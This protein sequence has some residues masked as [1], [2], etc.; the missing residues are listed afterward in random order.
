M[1][2]RRDFKRIWKQAELDTSFKNMK[3]LARLLK[4]RNADTRLRTL[5]KIRE[6]MILI[7]PKGYFLLA[8]RLID[9][10]DN[11]CRWQAVIIIGRFVETNPSEVWKV[12]TK[13]GISGDKDMR[14]AVGVVLLEDL[15]GY[16]FQKIFP[17]VKREV[18]RSPLFADTLSRCYATGQAKRYWKKVMKLLEQVRIKSYID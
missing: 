15:L 3:E 10:P 7:P 14:T 6:Q 13:Y 1:R 12:V 5:F 8:K 4:S 18:I 17:K 11:D 9:D 2:K 16:H